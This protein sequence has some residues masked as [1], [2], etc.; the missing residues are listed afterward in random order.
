MGNCHS[1]K[2]NVDRGKIGFL[3]VTKLSSRA[4][5]IHIKVFLTPRHNIVMMTKEGSTKILILI[6]QGEKGYFAST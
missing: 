4:V 5:N 6:Y 1:S 2:T 3:G